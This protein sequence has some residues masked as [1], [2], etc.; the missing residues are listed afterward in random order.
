MC[1]AGFPEP[2][3][4]SLRAA[5]QLLPRAGRVRRRPRQP[6]PRLGAAAADPRRD[7][8]RRHRPPSD[9]HRP[10]A[11]AGRRTVPAP[12]ADAA[13]LVRVHRHAGAGGRPPRRPDHR[14][15]ELAARHRHPHGR[16]PAERI[17]VIPVGIDPAEFTPP[18]AG[19]PPRPRLDPGHHQRRR[20]AQ[21]PGPPAGGAGQA[22]HRAPGAA[23]R[24]R[25]RPARAGR[26]RPRWT[27]WRCATPSASPARCPR[28]SWS[29]CCSG[30]PSWP[31][32]RC[33][34]GSR[35]RPSRRWPARR[36]WSPPTPGRC[37]RSSATRRGCGSAPGTSA[38]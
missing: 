12:A 27:G 30:P 25:H 8:D 24:R 3:T 16:G 4:F 20:R 37:P 15:G 19:Q 29:T 14:L 32:R 11:R 9:R 38:S 35:C 13:P 31:S 7:P 18:P 36:R 26:P 23:D 17:E 22:A 10:D 21:G 5:R 28:P 6:V 2:L 34:R 1:T 33:T